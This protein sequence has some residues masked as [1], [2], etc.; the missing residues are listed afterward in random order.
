MSPTGAVVIRR[1]TFQNNHVISSGS[2][3]TAT[4]G[5]VYISLN[6]AVTVTFTSCTF[7]AN[8][9]TYTS[10]AVGL[11]AGGGAVYLY[12]SLAF[13]GVATF[14]NCVFSRNRVVAASTASTVTTSS[15]MVAT[16]GAVLTYGVNT[17]FT[18]CRFTQNNASIDTDA[19]HLAYAG[20]GAV[21]AYGSGSITVQS[22]TF[23]QNSA[24]SDAASYGGAICMLSIL[25]FVTI[26]NS[27][28]LQNIALA[29]STTAK[30][31]YGGA[32]TITLAGGIGSTSISSTTFTQNKAILTSTTYSGSAGACKHLN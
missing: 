1:C 28:F 18:L 22:C 17:T 20:G 27:T 31:A 25:G 9:V 10:S 23:T 21:Y 32:L 3:I 7:V 14:S 8:S 29:N 2:G 4:G 26:K 13:Q 24:K 6:S 16:G 11:S 15:S 12:G 5:A 19:S 30:L